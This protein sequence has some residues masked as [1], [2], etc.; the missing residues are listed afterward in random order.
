MTLNCHRLHQCK[1]CLC[2]KQWQ[3]KLNNAVIYTLLLF[4]LWK[5]KRK[6]YHSVND[7]TLSIMQ[8]LTLPSPLSLLA[9]LVFL[10]PS[11][12]RQMHQILRSRN[13]VIFIAPKITF[14]NKNCSSICHEH[15][16]IF[17]N[18]NHFSQHSNT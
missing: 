2:C 7:A 12:G 3:C 16:L 14:P 13:C 15:S 1:Q 5:M 8:S 10:K 11:F 17:I 18:N 4:L 6:P 9:V